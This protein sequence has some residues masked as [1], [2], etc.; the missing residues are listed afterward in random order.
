MCMGPHLVDVAKAPEQNRLVRREAF[1]REHQVA[2]TLLHL[3]GG[4]FRLELYLR[5]N[6]TRGAEP[7]FDV[8]QLCRGV[9]YTVP[10]VADFT[11]QP[12]PLFADL[13]E[14]TLALL[15]L[16]TEVGVL[17]RGAGRC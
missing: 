15:N 7:P 10:D 1:L 3:L 11:F 8:R 4:G 5:Q 13:L 2:G 6:R 16:T 17:R 12:V 9:P 14:T